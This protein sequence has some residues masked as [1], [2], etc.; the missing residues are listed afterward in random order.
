MFF[1]A[2]LTLTASACGGVNP[3]SDPPKVS[4][5]VVAYQGRDLLC[6]VMPLEDRKYGY[7]CNFDLFYAEPESKFPTLTRIDPKAL[8]VMTADY[9]GTKLHCLVYEAVSGLAGL[10]KNCDYRRWRLDGGKVR[11]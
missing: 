5:Q 9:F 11:V 1:A 3:D 10:S 6:Q 4:Y 7:D 8:R 2:L